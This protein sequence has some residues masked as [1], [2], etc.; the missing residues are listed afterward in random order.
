MSESSNVARDRKRF[1]I[2]H[3]LEYFLIKL[4]NASDPKLV[5]MSGNSRK[6]KDSGKSGLRFGM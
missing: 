6:D 5:K 3:V 2:I 4:N 1:S